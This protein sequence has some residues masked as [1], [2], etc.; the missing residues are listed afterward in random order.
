V[1]RLTITYGTTYTRVV[2]LLSEEP[3]LAAPLSSECPV[4]AGEIAYAARQESAVTLAD[5]LIRR[6]EAGSAGHPGATALGRASQV[7]AAESGWDE[8]RTAAEM[9]AV[10]E[11]YKLPA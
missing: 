8:S 6:T 5:A 4:T 7:M 9:T 10:N 11:F 1:R 3:A 2:Q